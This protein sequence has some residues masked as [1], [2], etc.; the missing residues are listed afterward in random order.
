MFHPERRPPDKDPKP[1]EA[2]FDPTKTVRPIAKQ[3]DGRT[4]LYQPQARHGPRPRQSQMFTAD[5][6]DSSCTVPP[7]RHDQLNCTRPRMQQVPLPRAHPVKTCGPN[8]PIC[9]AITRRSFNRYLLG[10]EAI[11]APPG[12]H[13]NHPASEH[14]PSVTSE[15]HKSRAFELSPNLAEEADKSAR[16]SLHHSKCKSRA[17]KLLPNLAQRADESTKP[18]HILQRHANQELLSS[19]Q[20]SLRE[21][22]KQQDHIYIIQYANRSTLAL[23]N[24][25]QGANE[26]AKPRLKF[27]HATSWALAKTL[28]R[29]RLNSKTTFYKCA[30]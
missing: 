19:R 15:T 11:L 24:P 4:M 23:P 29:E 14:T 6:F 12:V 13:E 5:R 26:L 8:T 3:L 9:N 16:P 18:R 27:K 20:T 10:T 30:S 7:Q 28:L 2:N 22:M 25:A 1:S 21:R 17:F